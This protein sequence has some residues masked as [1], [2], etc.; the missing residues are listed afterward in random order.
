MHLSHIEH[1]GIAVHDL[2]S[3]RE[4]YRRLLGVEPYAEEEVASEGV[5]TVF[6]KVGPNKIEL[7]GALHPESPVARFLEKKGEGLHHVAYRTENIV[8]DMRRLQ[9]A[10]FKLLSET[11]KPGAENMWVCF[12]HP[13][14]AQGVLTELCQPRL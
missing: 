3:A 8:A 14:D 9:E 11:P 13:K 12:V 1:I 2:E 6:F 7:L 5:K 4:K 10:G